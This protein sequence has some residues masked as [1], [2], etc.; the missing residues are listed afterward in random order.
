MPESI[1]FWNENGS[2][3]EVLVVYEWLPNQC[4]YC[5]RFGHVAQECIKKKSKKIRVPK[6]PKNDTVN[7]NND[8]TPAVEENVVMS[9]ATSQK[10]SKADVDQEGF[11]KALKPIRVKASTV[12]KVNTQK[13]F[14]ALDEQNQGG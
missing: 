14:Q 4:D 5:H 7:I 2:L 6:V 9:V 1:H 11:Q 12:S 13:H 8:I 10:P 3:T